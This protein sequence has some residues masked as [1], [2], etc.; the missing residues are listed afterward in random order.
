MKN[1]WILVLAAIILQSCSTLSTPVAVATNPPPPD[2]QV[3]PPADTAVPLPTDTQVPPTATLEPSP[4]PDPIIFR[5]DFEGA[6]GEGWQWIRENGK[7][8]NLTKNPG[9]LEIMARAGSARE[10]NISNLLLRQVPEGNF[11]IETKLNFKPTG[12]YQIAGLVLYESASEYIQF[13]RAYCAS[14]QCSGDGFYF[15]L[16]NHGNFTPENFATSAPDSDT[17]YLRLVRDGVTY[18]AYS[19]EDGKNWYVRGS[20]NVA[21]KPLFIGLI[22]GQAVNSVPKP[23]QFDYFLVNS[24]P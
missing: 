23:A 5:D 8:W 17:V 3:P 11:S 16:I 22:S 18:T 20:H 9:S 6:L 19:S 13:G 14:A 1:A 15:D 4:T 2:T 24:M 10:G 7:Y 21:L 12:K